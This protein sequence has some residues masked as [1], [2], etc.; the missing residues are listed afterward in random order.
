MKKRTEHSEDIEYYDFRV[1][2]KI[3]MVETESGSLAVDVPSDV[4]LV[5]RAL[6]KKLGEYR[7]S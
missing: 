4:E 1:T 6:R 7:D 5:E 2:K 3:R